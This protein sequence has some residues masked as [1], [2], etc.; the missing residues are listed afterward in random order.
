MFIP[1]G[2]LAD[3]EQT[4]HMDVQYARNTSFERVKR[5]KL[6]EAATGAETGARHKATGSTRTLYESIKAEG[7]QEPV[8]LYEPYG[9][10]P[11]PWLGE[12][13]H[14]VFTANAISPETLVPVIHRSGADDEPE[15]MQHF[16]K[17]R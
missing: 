2:E 14:R 11:K 4:E 16:G 5:S 12:G 9:D 15:M 13:H 17:F 6:K 10:S 3:P 7:V 1:A 8:H